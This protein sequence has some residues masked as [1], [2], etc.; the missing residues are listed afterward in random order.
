MRKSF[1]LILILLVLPIFSYSQHCYTIMDDDD[2]SN[3][4]DCAEIDYVYTTINSVKVYPRFHFVEFM[5]EQ[6]ECDH[7]NE[8]Y[9]ARKFAEAITNNMNTIL[10]NFAVNTNGG[11]QLPDGGESKIRFFSTPDVFECSNIFFWESYDD[12]QN[13]T[14]GDNDFDIIFTE[15][16]KEIKDDDGNVIGIKYSSSGQAHGS[17]ICLFNVHQDIFFE[18][19]DIE[20]VAE[21]FDGLG[22][23]E[24]FHVFGLG[25]SWACI[26]N[27]GDLDRIVEC[28]GSPPS[29]APCGSKCEDLAAD[30]VWGNSNN[31]MGYN[32]A[33]DALTNCQ[34]AK[35]FSKIIEE[36]PWKFVEFNEAYECSDIIIDQS[37]EPT[38]TWG[39]DKYLECNIEVQTGRELIFDNIKVQMGVGTSI[40]LHPGSRLII[41]GGSVRGIENEKGFWNGVTILKG[42]GS[43]QNDDPYLDIQLY[44]S[45]KAATLIFEQGKTS[46]GFLAPAILQD[47][48]IGVSVG[49]GL[50]KFS[51]GGLIYSEWGKIKNCN[52]GIDF[53][54]YNHYNKSTFLRPSTFDNTK[55]VVI[56]RNYGFTFD[57]VGFNGASSENSYGLILYNSTIDKLLSPNFSSRH[58]GITILGSHPS[59]PGFTV[60]ERDQLNIQTSFR[61]CDIGIA[62]TSF[63]FGDLE[64][65]NIKDTK[66]NFCETGI[67]AWGES[68]YNVYN[69]VFNAV[70]PGAIFS[71]GLSAGI[72]TNDCFCNTITNTST[73]PGSLGFGFAGN[74]Q[75]T[76]IYS[77]TF[78][79][80]TKSDECIK[81]EQEGDIF[82]IQATQFDPAAFPTNTNLPASNDFKD[83][84]QDL[85]IDDLGANIIYLTPEDNSLIQYF[86]EFTSNYTE[87]QSLLNPLPCND[88]V[89]KIHEPD[90]LVVGG[91][92]PPIVKEEWPDPIG[93][94]VLQEEYIDFIRLLPPGTVDESDRDREIA[95]A[96]YA[97]YNAVVAASA[98]P[99]YLNTLQQLSSNIWKRIEYG[100]YIQNEDYSSAENII[101]S[102]P[103]QHPSDDDFIFLQEIIIDQHFHEINQVHVP[104][105]ISNAEE[106]RI[107]SIIDRGNI[108]SGYASS[109]YFDL[110]G[111]VLLPATT[112][113]SI[114]RKSIGREI[115]TFSI[116]PNPSNNILYFDGLNTNEKVEIYDINN[117]KVMSFIHKN[118]VID[119]SSLIN[120]IYFVKSGSNP[121][122][123]FI[124]I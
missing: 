60:G 34:Y 33:Q 4:P 31:T 108:M 123:R 27:C 13:G 113:R 17:K 57:G 107:K 98:T 44:S 45:T 88:I 77:N 71:V 21:R 2:T 64:N 68:E 93:D 72:A 20:T 79:F 110:Y 116:Y 85:L 40:I 41:R 94:P 42:D 100:Y 95:R 1:Y 55:D 10:G 80:A 109:L 65:L 73:D 97:M 82:V 66:F 14:V 12:Y 105:T 102:M 36:K 26:T 76:S 92:M 86:P 48:D 120:G 89:N 51:G 47:A 49:D 91:T 78:G 111:Q 101:Q 96:E 119:I 63:G 75:N 59:M 104:F 22:I 69:N 30:G 81:T 15:K 62:F 87:L 74:N 53:K 46:G 83:S 32:P 106:I 39:C 61:V 122:I 52:I 38:T 84:D 115:S 56:H 121:I 9:D 28:G 7:P 114:P 112:N 19:K 118:A 18:N 37:Y 124:K 29:G 5:G 103:V 43:P 24:L 90:T 3:S 25:H 23:H 54:P 58:I 8:N 50:T 117:N 67:L 11:S 99:V 35:A 6:F 16:G 70:E